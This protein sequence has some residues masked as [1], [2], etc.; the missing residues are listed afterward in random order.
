MSIDYS[1][2]PS[3]DTN[4]LHLL[5]HIKTNKITISVDQFT[6]IASKPTKLYYYINDFYNKKLVSK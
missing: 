3:E 4:Q 1:I 5:N 2:Y 6:E